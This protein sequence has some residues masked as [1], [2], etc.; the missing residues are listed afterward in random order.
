MAAPDNLGEFIKYHLSDHPWPGCQAQLWGQTV[1][2]MSDGIAT[3]V[4]TAGVLVAVILLLA[5]RRQTVPRGAANALEV[6][7]VFVRDMIARPALKERAYRYLPF[8]LTL[9]VFILGMNV[10]GLLPLQPLSVV[11]DRAMGGAG[12]SLGGTP[13]GVLTVCAGLASL[14]LLHIVL[15]GLWRAGLRRRDVSNWPLPVCL[16]LSPVLWSIGLAPR[17][18]GVAG[19][20]MAVPLAVLELIG[21]VAK[22]FALMIRLFANML[23]GHGML[24]VMM[25]FIFRLSA[26]WLQ[27]SVLRTVGVGLVCILASVV[28]N[29]LELMVAGLQAYIFTFLSAMFLSLYVEPQH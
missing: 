5:R 1:T 26:D 4:L 17:V 29:V 28:V 14:T 21:T 12:Y 25:M 8:L 3:M 9:F 10:I 7:V 27:V 20:V 24:A 16:L 15:S 2:W 23:A 22:C 6:V 13:T 19:A 18:Q 11:L